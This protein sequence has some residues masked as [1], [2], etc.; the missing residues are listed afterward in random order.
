MQLPVKAHYATLAM[1]ALAEKYESREVLPARAIALE[2]SIPSQF[3][4]QILQ[5]LRAAGLIAST[6]GSS[7]GFYLDRAPCCVTVGEVVD[8]VCPTASSSTDTQASPLS[9]VV[10]EVWEELKTQQREV[11]DRLT[12]SELLAR[13]QDSSNSMFY[14]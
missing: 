5:Q 7:G 12:I 4:T 10:N 6:R 11:L 1:L 3:L 8:A 9:Q 14:I 13:S 2:Q